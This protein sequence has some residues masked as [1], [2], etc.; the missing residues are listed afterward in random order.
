MNDST[1]SNI[2]KNE[3]KIY[4]ATF[5]K[6]ECSNNGKVYLRLID[7]KNDEGKIIQN[8]Y[9]VDAK[10]QGLAGSLILGTEITFSALRVEESGNTS[11]FRLTDFCYI[12]KED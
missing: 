11:G 2:T 3:R 9:L 10:T 12:P 4:R 7:I 6:Y 5:D 1:I 8:S